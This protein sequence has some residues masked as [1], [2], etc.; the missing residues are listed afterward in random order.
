MVKSWNYSCENLEYESDYCE[1][2]RK[3]LYAL[4]EIGTNESINC[5]KDVLKNGNDIVSNYAKNIL[6]EYQF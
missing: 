1:F 6:K 4:A 2:N 5:I 3:C